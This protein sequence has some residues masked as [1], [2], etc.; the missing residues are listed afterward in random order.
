MQSSLYKWNLLLQESQAEIG[1]L[2]Q[3]SRKQCCIVLAQ[4]HQTRVQKLNPEN[5]GVS[6]YIPLQAGY[7]SKKQS[8]TY[9][10]LHVT[11]LAISFPQ[12]YVTFF[13][14]Q[15]F[16]FYLSAMPSLHPATLSEHKLVCFF[17]GPPSCYNTWRVFAL[18][19]CVGSRKCFSSPFPPYFFLLILK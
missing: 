7:R 3:F 11:L 1:T 9:I 14:F 10:W 15:V 18:I 2:R 4:T 12:C 19:S 17:S 8:F 5:K 6:P 16:K 13:M